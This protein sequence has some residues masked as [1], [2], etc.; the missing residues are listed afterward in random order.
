MWK[1][2]NWAVA[3]S[4]VVAS[5]VLAYDLYQIPTYETTAVVAVGERYPPETGNAKI[6]PIPNASTHIN[7]E[8]IPYRIARTIQSPDVAQRVVERLN[9]PRGSAEK[10]RKNISAEHKPGTALIDVTYTTDTPQIAKQV[11]N[12]AVR[13]TQH[14]VLQGD[15]TTT[16]L[17]TA[18]PPDTPVSPNPLRDTLITLVIT[19]MLSTLVVA[20]REYLRSNHR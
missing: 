20:V 6:Q 13:V 1:D 18:K 3:V 9:L 14:Y 8:N 16:L 2:I 15:F 11:A 7:I 10:V 17:K 5:A 12:T 19:L 4:L